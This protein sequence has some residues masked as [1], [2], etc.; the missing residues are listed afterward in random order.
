MAKKY[1]NVVYKDRD[2]AKKLGARWDASV[3]QWYVPSGSPL[4]KIFSWRKAANEQ[5]VRRANVHRSLAHA[6]ANDQL[7]FELPLAS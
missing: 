3:K 4:A 1:I 5:S 7:N 2:L 6:R